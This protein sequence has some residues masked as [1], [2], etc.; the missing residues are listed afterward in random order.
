[1][2]W[3]QLCGFILTSLRRGCATV[4]FVMN[5]PLRFSRTVGLLLALTAA[6][7]GSPVARGQDSSQ[8]NSPEKLAK[9]TYKVS[10]TEFVLL[11]HKERPEER[12]ALLFTRFNGDVANY[13]WLYFN[14]LTSDWV[15]GKGKVQEVYDR[16]KMRED[17][18]GVQVVTVPGHNTKIQA[19][20][21]SVEWSRGGVSSGWIYFDPKHFTLEAFPAAQ[22]GK[23][24]L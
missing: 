20:E 11:T 22:F 2:K 19:G 3:L 15:T 18:K 7:A 16:V 13:K 23:A 24:G 5:A 9:G 12:L 8:E 6:L 14:P 4:G 21:I 17:A 1:M 10:L